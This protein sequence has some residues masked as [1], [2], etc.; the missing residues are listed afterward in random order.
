MVSIDKALRLFPEYRRPQNCTGGF[1]LSFSLEYE[2][3]V[4]E[5]DF[6]RIF[7]L[8]SGGESGKDSP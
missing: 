1:L 8:D 6:Q 7:F 2:L 4:D 3:K 5:N